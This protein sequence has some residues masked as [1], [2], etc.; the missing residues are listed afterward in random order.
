M[1][2]V[3]AVASSPSDARQGLFGP[4]PIILLVCG[5]LFLAVLSLL[6]P[7]TPTYDPW[8]WIIWGREIADGHLNTREGPSWKPLPVLFTTLFAPAGDAA[9][10]L[11]LVIAR[12][13]A[14]LG[15][16]M[17]Y[18]V[19]S[20]LAGRGATGIAAGAIAVV[21]LGLSTDWLRNGALGNSEGLLV[22]LSLWAVERHLD[23]HRGHALGLGFAAGLLR[24]EV[25]PFLGLYAL[26]LF[27]REPRRRPLV[28]ALMLLLPVLWLAPELW[29]SGDLF[30]ASDR[31]L[32]PN[33]DSPAFAENPALE[34]LGRAAGMLLVPVQIGA[35]VAVVLALRAPLDRR[36]TLAMTCMAAIALAWVGLVALM[37]ENG[38]SGNHRYLILAVALVSVLGGVGYAR[39]AGA[40]G[41]FIAA[42]L[43]RVSAAPAVSLAVLVLLAAATVP[44]AL[45]PIRG[46]PAEAEA[47]EAEAGSTRQLEFAVRDAGGP[48]RVLA[49][50]T[51]VTGPF[52]VPALAWQLRIAQEEVDVDPRLPGV[53]FSTRPELYGTS[54][55]EPARVPFHPIA[56]AG[57]WRVLAACSSGRRQQRVDAGGARARR[58]AR[59]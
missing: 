30:R 37:T 58:R 50:G 42:R 36:R 22:A 41:A 29:G 39:A 15:L 6:L 51:A 24:P 59:R 5:C 11:W 8:A 18:R 46:L 23:G 20:R 43:G 17:A 9:P 54:A 3:N 38:Y 31:A 48:D 40:T 7:S 13:S 2:Q 1:S 10:A 55:G 12:A 26:Y 27:V 47:I 57:E 49:C 28:A 53:V 4:H 35:L 32:D 52:E 44:F 33:P 19:A 45:G 21:A 25:W 14:L 56:R 34:V 16:V